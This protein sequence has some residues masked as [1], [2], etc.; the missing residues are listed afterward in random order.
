M[1]LTITAFIIGF[2]LS[3]LVSI[4]IVGGFNQQTLTSKILATFLGILVGFAF[5]EFIYDEQNKKK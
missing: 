4:Y 5:S 1:K 3:H 2:I